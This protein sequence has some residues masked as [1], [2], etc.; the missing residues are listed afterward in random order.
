MLTNMIQASSQKFSQGSGAGSYRSPQD[1]FIMG[2]PIMKI[3]D[4][5]NL[6]KVPYLA[7]SLFCY[8]VCKFSLSNLH[9]SHRSH[10]R[11]K[12]CVTVGTTSHV[13]VSN[14]GWY[15][16]GCIDC[17]KQCYGST[18]TFKCR[19]GHSTEVPIFRLITFN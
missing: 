1:K 9:H 16:H 13:R 12:I 3:K 7:H 14:N 11:D 5:V 2:H 6:K 4:M 10:L 19:D 18:P 8:I 15:F 17:I